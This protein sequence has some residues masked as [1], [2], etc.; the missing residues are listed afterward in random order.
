MIAVFIDEQN[1]ITKKLAMEHFRP[2]LLDLAT[3]VP[4]LDQ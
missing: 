2:E 4:V 3:L 1:K